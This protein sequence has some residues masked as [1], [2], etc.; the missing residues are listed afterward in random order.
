MTLS[1]FIERLRGTCDRSNLVVSYDIRVL[2]NAVLKARITLTIDPF[3][4]VYYN[5][6][7]GTCSYT[8]IQGGQRI[9]GAD[10]AF[11][12]WHIHPFEN[13][14][15]HRL[16]EAVTFHEFLKTVEQWVSHHPL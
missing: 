14:D 1:H 11:I 5:P 13:Q 15:E 10:N 4:D 7:N 6:A 12:G 8:L 16:R 3:I 9:F 2:D